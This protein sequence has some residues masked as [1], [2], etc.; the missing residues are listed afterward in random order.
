[1]KGKRMLLVLL[2]AAL[3]AAG[4]FASVRSVSGAG[5][6][7][8]QNELVAQADGYAEKELYVRAIPLYEEALTLSSALNP[9]IEEKLLAVY[10]AYGDFS[11]YTRLVEKRAAQKTAK[12]TEYIQAADCYMAGSK[13][14]E[15]MALIRKGME[16]LD[17]AEPG[18]QTLE[19]YYEAH[20]YGYQVRNTRLTAVTPTASNSWM[21][22]FDGEKWGYVDEK[23]MAVLSFVYDSATPFNAEGRAVVSIEGTYCT[24]LRN[25][26][27]YGV[28]DGKQYSR[29]TDVLT[30]SGNR[31]LGKRD[32][33]YSYFNFDFEPIASGYQFT[34]MTANACG[35]AAVKKDSGWG[36]IT[37]SGETVLDYTLEEVAVN[38][39]GCAFA[40]N[41]AMVKENGSWY[42]IDPEG[43]RVSETG[44]AGAK[45]P[46]SAG[47]IA[48]ADET[49]RWGFIDRDGE[50]TIAYQYADALSFSDGL[51]AVQTGA[52][53]GYI[54]EKNELVIEDFWSDA[55]PFH[56]GIAQV[57]FA[58][59]V[60]L[61]T[62]NY[63]EK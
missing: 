12:E 57:G 35:V 3:L 40:G 49:G 39:L 30:V 44:Y 31:V 21:P 46:E 16:N 28:D 1:M 27:R 58:G 61:L 59:N 53:W 5:V 32:G 62:L 51:A 26:D 63:Q 60:S 2:F 25:G 33:S 37:D 43:N 6:R 13:I 41:R 24:I 48:V 14:Q 42:L 55:L 29:L 10:R 11:S 56:N 4:W 9:A 45:A 15:A 52:D 8:K 17:P 50:L 18:R 19:T 47:Y 34:Q 38:S 54:S 7:E 23:G 36:I 20:R 22:A